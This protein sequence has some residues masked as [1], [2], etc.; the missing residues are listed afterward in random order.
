MAPGRK[1][2]RVTLQG[3]SPWIIYR[4][5]LSRKHHVL[6]VFPYRDTSCFL[7]SIPDSVPLSCLMLPGTHETMALYGW[8]ISQCQYKPLDTQLHAGIRV[9]DIRL[10]I[11]DGR[12]IAYHGIFPEFT[13]FADILVTLHNFLTSPSTASETVVV[14]IKQEDWDT[15]LF[16]QLVHDEIVASPGGLQ[17][18]FLENRIPNLGEVRGKA[19][20]F[21]RFGSDGCT[22]GI[23][24][25]IWPDSAKE[26]FEWECDG[27]LVRTHDWYGIPSFLSIHEKFSL[28]M[29]ILNP[30]NFPVPTL[31]ISFTSAS[32]IPLALPPVIARGFG[33]PKWGLGF[34]GVNHRVGKWLLSQL[35]SDNAIRLQNAEVWHMD[36]DPRIRGWVLMDYYDDPIDAGIVPLLVECNFRGRMAGE[37]G[38]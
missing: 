37:E 15:E 1:W 16:P 13:P 6:V 26:G 9:T 4:N 36:P 33:W 2:E 20:M 32:S 34:E 7:A 11:I 14:S 31:S 38:W 35:S 30:P 24:P 12:L 21:S 19:V 22:N 29:E 8:P 27:T 3:D 10:S 25:P 18:W 23:H 17:M 5:R 28:S